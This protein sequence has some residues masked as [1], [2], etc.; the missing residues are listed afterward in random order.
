ML[1]L[2]IMMEPMDGWEVLRLLEKENA[3]PNHIYI[4]SSSLKVTDI[5]HA[6][7]LPHVDSFIKKPLNKDRLERILFAMH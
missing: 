6:S 3:L 5:E 1:L 2:D 4:L 7:D